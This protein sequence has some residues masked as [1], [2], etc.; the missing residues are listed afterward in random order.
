MALKKNSKT[1]VFKRQQPSSRGTNN[2]PDNPA[3][4][5]DEESILL[6]AKRFAE[7]NRRNELDAQLGF[8]PMET[9]TRMG[10][11]LNM[12]SVSLPYLY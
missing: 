5:E 11:M 2:N 6:N 9:G 7:I 10:W 4:G 3:R 12:Q 8:P 1:T